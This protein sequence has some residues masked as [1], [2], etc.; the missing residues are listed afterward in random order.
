MIKFS[1]PEKPLKTER[2]HLIFTLVTDGMNRNVDSSM[3]ALVLQTIETN[4]DSSC[5]N[6]LDGSV[7]WSNSLHK[8]ETV[9][10]Y[11]YATRHDFWPVSQ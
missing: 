11:H 4:F 3:T 10:L 9:C 8:N 5:T 7:C 6:L 1:K 2:Q